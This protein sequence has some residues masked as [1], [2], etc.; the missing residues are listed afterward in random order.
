MVRVRLVVD[1]Y[2]KGQI[3]GGSVWE[4]S[5]LGWISM[6]RKI[7]WDLQKTTEGM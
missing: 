5:D 6:G 4:V 3:W 1:Q 7:K 2:G